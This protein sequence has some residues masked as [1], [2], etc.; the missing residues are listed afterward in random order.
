MILEIGNVWTKV[1]GS[2]KELSWLDRV[3]AF[4]VANEYARKAVLQRGRFWDGKHHFFHHKRFPSGLVRYA[5]Q[6]ARARGWPVDLL[7][8]RSR[9]PLPG[10]VPRELGDLVLRD[11]QFEAAQR[12]L[13]RGRGILK[14]ATGSGKSEIACAV[15]LASRV[16]F[17]VLV[18]Q[19]HLMHQF[20]DRWEKRTGRPAGRVGEGLREGVDSAPVVVATVPTLY[21]ALREKDP[22]LTRLVR[23]VGGFVSDECHR[24]P[25]RTYRQV[26]MNTDRAFYRFGIS[27]TPLDRGDGRSV[28]LVAATAGIVYRIQA[29]DLIEEGTLARPTIRFIEIPPTQ[30]E[31]IFGRDWNSVY[32]DGISDCE[33]RNQIVCRVVHRAPKPCLVFVRRLHHGRVLQRVLESNGLRVQFVWG[34][35]SGR[36]RS[37]SVERLEDGRLEVV[38]SN[39]FDEGVDIPQLRSIVNAAGGRSTI[40]ALQRLGRAMRVVDG[41]QSCELWDFFDLS[42]RWL[43]EHAEERMS[44]YLREGFDVRKG[45][46]V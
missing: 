27:G 3:L 44:V 40:A 12:L 6:K 30:V 25:S 43:S 22:S 28:F 34:G 36:S 17:L 42:H 10:P 14:A 16:R 21:L 18:H 38:V 45:A 20:A 13:S 4:P 26:V 2:G 8:V 32:E 39:V 11:D 15:I 29:K 37:R 41:K 33:A 35:H 46:E 24:V 9:P 5:T 1:A 31:P 23:T 7:D 19:I